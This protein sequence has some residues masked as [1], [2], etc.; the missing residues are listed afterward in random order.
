[1]RAA[2]VVAIDWFAMIDTFESVWAVLLTRPLAA[3]RDAFV[4]G[5][6]DPVEA[7]VLHVAP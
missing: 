7:A 6:A 5:Q 3:R 2:L 4:F 1:M